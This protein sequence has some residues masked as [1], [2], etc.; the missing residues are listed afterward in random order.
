MF[1]VENTKTI[2][3]VVNG[4]LDCR[5]HCSGRKTVFQSLKMMRDYCKMSPVR[6]S[7]ACCGE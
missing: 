5:V 1:P 4:L 3:N 6:N 2:D 7:T